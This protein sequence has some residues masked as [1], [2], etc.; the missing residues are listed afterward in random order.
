MYIQFHS[1]VRIFSVVLICSTISLSIFS[2]QALICVVFW[3]QEPIQTSGF[4][5]HFEDLEIK[6]VLLDEIMRV[7]WN[8]LDWMDSEL[9]IIFFLIVILISQKLWTL[10][11]ISY[12]IFQDPEVLNKDYFINFE[13]RSLRDSRA[14]I[15]KVEIE[16]AQ[17]IEDNPHLRLWCD[18]HSFHTINGAVW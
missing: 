14:L 11:I 15:E 16:D 12:L 13:I 3:T 8:I 10:N 5:C 7:G 6:S 1:S 2:W 18:T 9:N 4:I 17:F